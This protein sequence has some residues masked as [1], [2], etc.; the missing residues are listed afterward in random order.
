[1]L[2]VFDLDDT[3]FDCTGQMKRETKWEDAKSIR[4]FPGVKEFLS[5]F[6]GKKVLVTR[7]TYQGLQ[8]IKIDALGI[9][10]FFDKIIICSSNDEKKAC[11]RQLQEQF[12]E[13]EIAVIGDRIDVEIRHAK[14]LGMKAIRLRQGKHSVMAPSSPAEVP[15]FEIGNFSELQQLLPAIFSGESRG[16][17]G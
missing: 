14:E 1:M 12:S 8:N 9:R 11:L 15:D 6:P 7:E 13:Q 16:V 3:L 10:H 2:L 5:S 17:K 4:L